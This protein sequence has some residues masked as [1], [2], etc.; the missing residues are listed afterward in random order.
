ML[1]INK[2]KPR[3]DK[4][5]TFTGTLFV[6]FPAVAEIVVVFI[7]QLASPRT[8]ISISPFM[9]VVPVAV[10]TDAKLVLAEEN[11]TVSP[12]ARHHFF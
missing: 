7:V 4:S 11:V 2:R 6:T 12:G 10:D 1:A 5:G 8:V 9:L 3:T